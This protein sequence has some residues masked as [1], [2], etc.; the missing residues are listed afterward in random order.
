MHCTL[1]TGMTAV[2]TVKHINY[3]LN[4]ISQASVHLIPHC[5]VGV[6]NIVIL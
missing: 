2:D 1:N 4:I 3:V 6:I 5:I